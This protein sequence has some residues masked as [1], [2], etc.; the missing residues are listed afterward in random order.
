MEVT[1]SGSIFWRCRDCNAEMSWRSYRQR[2]VEINLDSETER[3]AQ[4]P[5]AKAAPPQNRGR[6]SA[7]A[8]GFAASPVV[9][10]VNVGTEPAPAPAVRTVTGGWQQSAPTQ[11]QVDYISRLARSLAMDAEEVLQRVAS[12][13]DATAMIDE[14][15]RRGAR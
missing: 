14:L 3:A 15:K 6:A 8:R 5:R 2:G 10:T 13:A 12:K 9:Q 1:Y 4:M 11:R 7:A